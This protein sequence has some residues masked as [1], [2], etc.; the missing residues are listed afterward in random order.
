MVSVHS[1]N[2]LVTDCI[3]DDVRLIGGPTPYQGTVELCRNKVWGGV[4]DT[5]W[6]FNG[7][8]LVCSQLGLHPDGK[9]YLIAKC[10]D[11]L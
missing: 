5:G 7:A 4:C 3:D 6:N 9:S 1:D 10:R 2:P 11:R 8:R